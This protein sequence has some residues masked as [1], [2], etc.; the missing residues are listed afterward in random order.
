MPFDAAKAARIACGAGV[1]LMMFAGGQWWSGA[2]AFA[3]MRA[4]TCSV[5]S[6]R[7]ESTLLVDSRRR[8][9]NPPTARLRIEAHLVFA[10]VLDG[11]PYTFSED[12]VY[13]WAV[14]APRGYEQGNSYPCRYDPQEPARGTIRDEADSGGAV[15]TLL[16]G[17][18]A[19]LLGVT[20][21]ATRPRESGLTPKS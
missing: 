5:V 2:R 13:D 19:I 1:L 12:F 11:R 14:Y 8:S 9:L 15:D 4:T 7:L 10:H 3:R 18:A 21:L 6:K 20:V 16:F 17:C